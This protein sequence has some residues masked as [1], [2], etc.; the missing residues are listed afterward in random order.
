MIIDIGFD[1]NVYESNKLLICIRYI[2]I[3]YEIF[4][5]LVKYRCN[6]LKKE[7]EVVQK[8]EVEDIVVMEKMF[9]EVEV[10]LLIITVSK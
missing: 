8:K 5:Y 7:M 4:D 2:F 1:M 10:N 9:G 3:Y 6:K